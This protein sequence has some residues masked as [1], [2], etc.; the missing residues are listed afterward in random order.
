MMKKFYAEPELELI[1]V[2][3]EADVLGLSQEDETQVPTYDGG[4]MDWEQNGDF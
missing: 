3:L 2:K 1:S 4:G